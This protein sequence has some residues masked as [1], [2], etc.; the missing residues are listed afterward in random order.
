MRLRLSL[1]ITALAGALLLVP[2]T[3]SAYFVHVVA[4]GESLFSIA[5]TDGL[6]VDQLAAAN[7][8]SPTTQL[9]TGSTL[10][11]PPQGSGT[12]VASS[13]G[14]SSTAAASSTG[15][16]D[17]DADDVGSTA[18]AAPASS[19]GAYVVQ[20][21]DTLTGIASRAGLSPDSLAAANGLDANGVLISGTVLRLSG[22]A[23][24]VPVSTTVPVSTSSS[25]SGAYVVQ[26]GDTL[27]A[28]ATRAGLSMRS[29][30]A[31]NG[32]DPNRVLVSGTVLHLSG[33]PAVVSSV[34]SAS[35]ATSQPVGTAAEG[36]PT[37]PPYPT[38]ERVTAPQIGSIAAQNGVPASLAAAI[39]WQ[40]SGFNNDLV[41]S[42]DARG[43]MQILPGTW[44]WIQNTLDTGGPPLAPASAADNVRGGVLMLHSLLG[45]TGGDAA[46]AA[47]GYYQGLPSVQQHGMY[48]DTQ[49]YVQN[50]LSL[51]RQFGGG[52]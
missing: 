2:A 35:A 22:G 42:A 14:A 12:A 15:D 45:A 37:D 52:G 27:T 28:I 9:V 18:S 36:T 50:V 30:A 49:R 44:Q 41:S 29:L 25:S 3:A 51:E 23:A 17:N 5:A 6:T 4:P 20:P 1:L 11:I 31:A 19:G 24:M 13:S 39:A 34:S 38:P 21:G 40:E 47:A 33:S 48:P 32:I 7:G 26:P 8:L 16:G 46:M 43:V 10:Q